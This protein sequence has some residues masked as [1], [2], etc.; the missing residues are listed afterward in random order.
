MHHL[1]TMDIDDIQI[2]PSTVTA[3]LTTATTEAGDIGL[4]WTVAAPAKTPVSFAIHPG[5]AGSPLTVDASTL[6]RTALA[7]LL[8]ATDVEWQPSNEYKHVVVARYGSGA[9]VACTNESRILSP[10]ADTMTTAVRMEEHQG[11][12]RRRHGHLRLVG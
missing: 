5:P 2:S 1:Q 9:E 12:G 8:Q 6:I 4:N 7:S 3:G 10:A 11:K